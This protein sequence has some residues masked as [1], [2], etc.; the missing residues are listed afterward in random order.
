MINNSTSLINRINDL[1]AEPVRV[2]ADS[3]INKLAE[4]D[5]PKFPTP[6]VL[7]VKADSFA[8]KLKN[9]TSELR[10]EV[11]KESKFDVNSFS[12]EV[13][14]KNNIESKSSKISPDQVKVLEEVK[15]KIE[16]VNSSK[17]EVNNNKEAFSNT[18]NNIV[19]TMSN[20]QTSLEN[21]KINNDKSLNS[22][23]KVLSSK[24]DNIKNNGSNEEAIIFS[25][26]IEKIATKMNEVKDG[27]DK[28]PNAIA[29]V[30]AEYQKN[31]SDL[32]RGLEKKDRELAIKALTS[33]MGNNKELIDNILSS[34]E[35][36]M[37]IQSKDNPSSTDISII[38]GIKSRLSLSLN[39]STFA[40]TIKNES[41]KKVMSNND[42]NSN[43]S[44]V[45]DLSEKTSEK[46][47]ILTKSVSKLEKSISELNRFINSNEFEKLIN[48][49]SEFESDDSYLN[50][51]VS[52]LINSADKLEG[53]INFDFTL[54]DKTDISKLFKKLRSIISDLDISSR[55]IRETEDASKL[56]DT[57]FLKASKESNDRQIYFN[58]QR[59]ILKRN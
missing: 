32:T 24:M 54:D 14:K 19:K 30:Q 11:T 42:V 50:E 48:N 53:N 43:I 41:I 12:F 46:Y 22:Y 26:F 8:E 44:N 1:K 10:T 47:N 35:N 17:V 28:S 13:S 51:I 36:K 18:I 6:E 23:F 55:K 9:I 5:R 7:K 4:S 56:I 2:K 39:E 20:I 29:T 3:F 58:Q 45:L 16:E 52:D 40:H 57:N 49:S 59:Q 21:P 33:I 37:S 34:L 31:V 38:R 25:K 27:K 15:N